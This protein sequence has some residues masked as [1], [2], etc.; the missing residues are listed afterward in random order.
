MPNQPEKSNERYSDVAA[1]FGKE[2]LDK[3]K[4]RKVLLVGAGGIGCE[5]LKDLVMTGF[6]NI[7]VIDLDTIGNMCLRKTCRT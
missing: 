2:L 1:I 5:V 7:E 3:V 4:T 6:E